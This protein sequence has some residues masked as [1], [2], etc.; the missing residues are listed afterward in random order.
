MGS[1][2][3]RY[4]ETAGTHD[5]TMG[6]DFI[7]VKTSVGAITLVFP[8]IRDSGAIP[9]NK[10]WFVNDVDDMAATNNVTI[11]S[12]LTTP[13]TELNGSSSV[14]LE[15]DGFSAEIVPSG[16]Y[17]YM[18]N[19]GTGEGGMTGSGTLNYIV[20]FTPSGNVLGN[21]QLYDNGTNVGLGTITPTV[22]FDVFTNSTDYVQFRVGNSNQN[23]TSGL[24]LGTIS[25]N[26]PTIYR[27]GNSA[28]GISSDYYGKMV[29]AYGNV[30]NSITTDYVFALSD[31]LSIGSSFRVVNDGGSLSNGFSR[32][33]FG[34][35]GG[36]T[37]SSVGIGM[38]SAIPT[39]VLQVIGLNEY[40]DNA[41]AVTAGLT[42]GAFYRTGD[43][44]KVVH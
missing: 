9:S 29:F 7:N 30:N 14:V 33:I 6:D 5:I 28:T 18:V 17:S 27:V 26:K 35:Y 42:A 40:A 2:N 38:G 39:A 8:N 12:A 16:Y 1:G 36:V 44:L 21:S 31:N 13:A 19:S 20:K 43:L 37:N 34:V 22:K 11:V 41:A 15:T 3:Q 23:Y 4:I 10:V 25:I 24:E 32:T